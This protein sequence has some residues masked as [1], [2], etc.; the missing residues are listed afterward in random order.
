[1]N[2]FSRTFAVIDKIIR[3]LRIIS[4]V[5][6]IIVQISFLVLY[7]FKIFY[8]INDPVY[9]YIYIA[10]AALSLFGFVFYLIT[11]NNRKKKAIIGTKR[12][13]RIFKYLANGLMIIMLIIEFLNKDVSDLEVIVSWISIIGFLVQLLIEFARIMFERYASLMVIALKKDTE[14]IEDL[15]NPKRAIYEKINAPLEKLSQKYTGESPV[16]V[17]LSKKEL[18][19][20]SLAKEYQENNQSKRSSK[21]EEKKGEVKKEKD[22]IKKNIKIIA[23]HFFKRKNK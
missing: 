20:E 6:L 15:Q 23:S 4:H 17:T 14:F 21:K 12:G 11:Y 7:G 13:I 5:F 3:D 18:Y 1:M 16:G 22:E 8:S 2:L 10:L 9:L 19:V